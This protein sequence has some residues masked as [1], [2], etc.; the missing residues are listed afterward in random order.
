MIMKTMTK[1]ICQTILF[2]LGIELGVSPR[3]ILSNL[4]SDND[5]D[6]LMEEKLSI[7]ELRCHVGA[8]KASCMRDLVGRPKPKEL[9]IP[10][11]DNKVLRKPF[12]TYAEAALGK[13]ANR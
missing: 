7:V 11:P 3:I 9:E 2:N 4:M 13:D 6:D 10:L 1:K 8:W 5:K 12:I